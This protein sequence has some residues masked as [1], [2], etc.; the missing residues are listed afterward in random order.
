VPAPVPRGPELPLSFAQQRLWFLDRMQPGSAVYNIPLAWRLRGP[1]SPAALAAALGEIQRRH[2][3]LRTRFPE[4]P[5]GN[6]GPVQVIEPPA[7]FALP[8]VDLGALPAAPRRRE[9]QR[10]VAAAARRPFDLARGPLLRARLLRLGA[11]DSVLVLAMHHVVADGWSVQVMLRELAT[12]YAAALAGPPA[13]VLPELPLQY[14]DFAVWQRQRLQG[15]LLRRLLAYWRQRLAGHPPVLALPSDRPRPAVRTLRGASEPLALGA[16]AAARLRQL[17]H[18]RGA[19]PFVAGLAGFLALLHR[20]TGQADLLVGTPSAGRDR[21]ELEGLIGFFVNTLV[22]RTDLGGDPSFLELLGRVRETA[23]GAYA[24]GELP[25]ERL[26]EELSPERSLGHSPL[27]QVTFGLAAEPAAAARL[28]AI[29]VEPL[30]LGSGT[31]KFDLSVYLEEAPDGL[32]GEIEYNRDLF[33]A[34]TVRRLAGHLG[35]LLAGAAAHPEARLSELPLLSAA[36]AS[37]LLVEWNDTAAGVPAPGVP[38]HELFAAQARRQPGAVAV[39]LGER[40]LT[41]GEL[42]ARAARLARRLRSRGVGPD[43]LV[44]ICADRGPEQVVGIVAALAAGGAY[45]CLDPAHP[46]ARLAWLLDDARPR[47]VLAEERFLGRLPASAAAAALVCLDR[48][49]ESLPGET[50]PERD[51]PSP[52]PPPAAAACSPASLAYVVYTSG[53]TGRPKPVAIPHQ[54]LLNLVLWHLDAYRV[55]PADRGTLVASP[56]FDASVWELWPLLA[57]GAAVH[58]PDEETRLS[59]GRLLRFWAEQA[60]TV[61]FL[62]TPL[63]EAVLQ[64]EVPPGLDL[65]L[66]ELLVGGDRL[67][68]APRPGLPFRLV[69]HY[70]P[71]ELGVVATVA[72]LAPAAPSPAAMPPIGRPIAN[73]RAYVLDRYLR[74]VPAGVAGELHVAGAGLARG[75]LRRPELTAE[76]FLPDPWTPGARMYRTGDLVRRLPD[77]DLDFLGRID[78]QVKLRGMRVE[79]GEIEAALA[80]QPGV[81]EAVALVREDHPGNRE[82]HPGDRE[83]PPGDRRLTAYVVAAGG[84]SPSAGELRACL[85][86]ELPAYMVPQDWVFLAA[87]PLTGNGKLDRRAL[88]APERRTAAAAPAAMP[89]TPLEELLAGIFRQVFGLPAVGV[90]EDFF[91]LGGH[92]L[93]ATQVVSRVGRLLGIDLEIRVLF[94]TPTIAGLAR[95]IVEERFQ[96][97]AAAPPLRRP[98]RDGLPGLPLSFAQQRLWF[99]DRLEPGSPFYNVPVALRLWGRLDVAALAGALAAVVGRHEALRTRF[100]TV[101]GVGGEPLQVIDPAGAAARGGRGT[102]PLIDLAG[103]PR[104]AR[105]RA[106]ERLVREQAWRPFDL[107]RGPLARF[108]LARLDDQEHALLLVLHHIV[109]DGWS[110]GVLIREVETL[111]AGLRAGTPPRLPE[112]PLQYAD[113]AVWQREWLRGEVLEREIGYWTQRLGASPQVLDLP[114]D[115]PR[116]PVQSFR[117]GLATRRLPRPLG[118]RID[119][120]SLAMGGTRFIVLLAAF[121]ALLGRHSYQPEISVGTPVAG[122][123]RVEIEGLIGFFV[124]TLVLRASLAGNPSFAELVGRAREAALSAHA[125]QDLPFEKLVEA[126]EPER[127]L[128]HAPLFQVMLLVDQDSPT[129]RLPGLRSASMLPHSGTAKFDLLLSVGADPDGGGGLAAEL[130]YSADLFDAPTAV[131]LLAQLETLLAGALDDPERRLWELPL[132]DAA[133]R[134]QLLRE[135]ND[136]AAPIVPL[137]QHQRFAARAARHPHRLALSFGGQ[138]GEGAGQLTYAE[139]EDR[140]N[141][142]AHLLRRRGVGPGVAVGV[143]LP[144]SLEV[145]VAVLAI[146]KAGGV[147]LPLD[148][149]YPADRLALMLADAGA[150]VLLSRRE[151]DGLLPDFTGARLHLETLAADLARLPASAPPAAAGMQDL[152][153]LIYTSGSTGRPKGIAMTHGALANLVGFHLDGG[154]PAGSA[155]AVGAAA[156]TLQFSPLS[157]DVCFQE[158][159]STWAAG[160]MVVLIGDD[161]RRDPE[162]LL[163][164]LQRERIGRL[165]LPFVALS[166]LAEAA[167]RRGAALPALREVVTAGEQLQSTEAIAGWFRRLPGCTLENQYG[168]SE[169]H[170]VTALRL[171]PDPAGWAALPP[172]GRPIRNLRLYLLDPVMRPV[173]IGVPGEVFVG[174]AQLARGYL[175]RPDQTAVRFLP[176]HLGGEAGER[177]YRTGDLARW[178]ADGNLEFRGRVDLQ[179]KVRGFRIELGEIE[180][181]LAEHPAVRAAV[182]TAPEIGRVRRLAAYVVPAGEAPDVA[183]LKVFLQ[184]RLPAYMVPSHWT[185]LDALPVAAT[186]KVDRQA[187]PPPAGQRPD[188]GEELVL[189]RTPLEE[190]VAE[191]WAE[192]LGLE[193]VGIHDSFWDLGGHSL[194]ATKVLARVN[195]SLGVDLRLQELFKWPTIAG[196]TTAIGESLLADADA[197]ADADAEPR[198]DDAAALAALPAS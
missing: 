180:T 111:Y 87:L 109:A 183:E 156:A 135:W 5:A 77:G 15:E 11:G 29:D 8:L 172:I 95:R 28:A 50:A 13:G 105:E 186:G 83:D 27:F 21:E 130:E 104:Q 6:G 40:R 146:W 69:N 144:R 18:A 114:A 71:S 34:A 148:P 42:A 103:L 47:V 33:D 41:Y 67:R 39:A 68:R 113:Y 62:P 51:Q 97:P 126:L 16:G 99:L 174:G 185:I 56:A 110:L 154:G 14:A 48:D 46:A 123:T 45:V 96:A 137:T 161:D 54:G 196:L 134:A 188:G 4:R 12:L 119:A 2:E 37:E 163:E 117:G 17:G 23:L 44:A 176:D 171:A 152:A 189:P 125:H 193:R 112:L 184:R 57:A 128:S 187:L 157:F 55:T 43:V 31:A 191:I 165:F 89:R 90:D 140:A 116:P 124:N 127:N 138:G 98:V 133:A 82:D 73:T 93:L 158:M 131:R 9:R 22:L 153:Y 7:P 177:L 30:P 198:L 192:V 150:P 175:G 159:C 19:P 20:A 1:L 53:S 197:D 147:L 101:G 139:V 66:R 121:Q 70:G 36:E 38:V 24:H 168:P 84:A 52:Q 75:Y 72:A 91:A 173:P 170:V 35:T 160:G 122:R 59:A 92:S 132:L 178:L 194:L 64:E 60:I 26:V 182:V 85:E 88:P 79:L 81:G 164:I 106:G 155:G 151:L 167:E 190:L 166:Q 169:A 102:L 74:P 65:R 143:C 25:F 136:H 49:L 61:A 108:A 10:L 86:R 142:L 149:A 58:V 162:A 120:A 78:H 94:E 115:R 145:P 129:W 80:R 141:R 179:V 76:R 3:A 63:A 195:V 118:A 181:A 100:V 32:A 107:A